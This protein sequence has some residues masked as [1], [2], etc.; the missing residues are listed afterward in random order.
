[1][2]RASFG[3]VLVTLASLCA[4]DARA[5]AT[6]DQKAAAQVLF[7]GGRTLVEQGRFAEACPKFAESQKLDPGIGTLLWLADCY[8]GSGQTASAWATFKEAAAAA[9]QGGDKREQVA[10][11]RAQILE[12]KLPR[13]MIVV[14]PE[15]ASQGLIVER[16][17]VAIGAPQ[18]GLPVPL[19]P[20]VHTLQAKAPDHK[21]WT[22]TV[23]IPAAPETLQVTV[24]V[25][26]AI[27]APLPPPTPIPIVPPSMIDA[28]PK[29][30]GPASGSGSAQRT[31]GLVVAG[32]GLIGVGVGTY[33]SL[34]AK[35]VYDDSTTSGHCQAGNQCDATGK[36]DRQNAFNQATVATVTMAVGAGA[37]ATGAVLYFIAPKREPIAVAFAPSLRGGSI[38]LSLDW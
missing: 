28:S 21:P 17:G 32:A 5:D 20:G 29:E 25:L 38:H 4:A 18:W 1:M 36:Q 22:T 23:Q 3:A 19:D 6:T 37:I 16:D 7:E 9:S 35:S 34:H 15:A 8:E 12:P 33:F 13:L 14:S 30:I 10:R 11:Q 26:D 31:V 2:R 24:P 27:E